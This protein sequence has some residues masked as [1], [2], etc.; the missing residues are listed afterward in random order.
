[1]QTLMLA[2]QSL[3]VVYGDLGTSPT[4]VLSSITVTNLTEEDLL[5]IFSL[6]FWSLTL[7]AQIKYIFVVLHADDHGEGGTFALYSN[8][9]RHINFQSK[10]AVKGTS[11]ESDADVI[12]H[13]RGSTLPSKTKRFIERSSSAQSLVTFVVLLGTCMVIGDG[14]LTPATCDHVVWMAVVLFIALFAFQRCGTN[15]IS[16]CFSPV[17]ILWY[18]SNVSIGIYNIIRYQP[19]VLKAISPHYIVKFFRSNGKIGW[20]LLGAVFLCVSGV[21][22]LFADLGHFNRRAVQLAFSFIVYPAMVLTYAGETAYLI[23]NPSHIVNAY[24]SS[25][26]APIYW[27]MF[28]ISNLAALVSSQSMISACFSIVKQ[29]LPLGF[30][31]RVNIIHTSSKYEGQVYSPEINYILMILCIGLV[32][33]FKGGVELA[34]AYGKP[35]L[36]VSL[37]RNN[38]MCRCDLG[39]DNNDVFDNISDADHLGDKCFSGGWVPFAISAFFL[40]IMLTWR[41][42]RI[43]K[44][45]Y[46][47][48]R[49]MSSIELDEMLSGGGV[50]RTPGI[51]FFYYDIVN[52]IPPIMRHYLQHTNS[53]QEIMVIVTLRSLPVISIRP[54]ER[55]IVGKLGIEGTYRC[56]LQ[57]GYNDDL[58]NME[59][60]D[61]VASIV[62][63]IREQAET[64]NEIQKIGSSAEKEV[65]FVIGRTLLKSNPN[66]GWLSRFAINYLYRF[67]QKNC[68]AEI[69]VL[70]MPPDRTLQVG[71]MIHAKFVRDL[72]PNLEIDSLK[73]WGWLENDSLK[74]WD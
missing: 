32:V 28:V 44:R 42:G 55:L 20:D 52:G 68:R 60:K 31:P 4:Q 25:I 56:L 35:R 12:S 59:E 57:F 62:A 16:L 64:N 48:E 14:A 7:L 36:I 38:S 19:S 34:N 6:I 5:G 49:K 15:K 70:E 45:T 67:I 9:C 17:M 47:A 27:P 51:C 24:Y 69:S 71:M 30:F 54:E 53:V 3:G 58:V 13:S 8:L 23:K 33:G 43:K 2:Y 66:N 1:M 73:L 40:T 46:E 21:E 18:A 72:P 74:L 50:Y 63:K 37:K 65:V 26:P 39:H 22:A 41:Y 29:S 61:Y 11:S 10:L